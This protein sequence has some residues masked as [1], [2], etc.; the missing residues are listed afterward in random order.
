MHAKLFGLSNRT[1]RANPSILKS[2]TIEELVILDGITTG[3]HPDEVVGDGAHAN[4][5]PEGR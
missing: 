5:P 1:T 4:G 2:Q 3:E